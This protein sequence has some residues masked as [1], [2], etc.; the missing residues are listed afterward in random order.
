MLVALYGYAIASR[1]QYDELDGRLR[2]VM[3]HV[4]GEL[5]TSAT[6]EG[7]VR[8]LS[9]ARG[10]GFGIAL[11]DSVGARIGEDSI[12]DVSSSDHV[13]A[14]SPNEVLAG[15]VRAPYGPLTAFVPAL[16]AVTPGRGAFGLVAATNTRWRVYVLPLLTFP[17]AEQGRAFYLVGSARLLDLDTSLR[18][19]WLYMI[20]IA[21]MGNLVT[22]A[23]GWWL[24]GRALHPVLALTESA[25]AIARSGAFTERVA[26]DMPRDEL[27]R[28]AE[29]FN[30]MLERLER[31]H[32][33]QARFISDA[34][35]ELRAPLTV[36][37]GN[38]E[39]LEHQTAMT[40]LERSAA[41]REAHLEANRLGRLVADLLVLARA[42]VGVPMHDEIVELDRV[43]MNVLGE[44]RHLTTGQRIV[45]EMLTPIAISGEADRLHQ[46]VLNLL[47]N[48]IKYTP[49]GGLITVAL[50]QNGAMA[51]LEIRDTGIGIA[52]N[53]LPHVFDRFFRAD[54]ARARDSGGTGLGLSIALW[55][56]K[57]H[58]GGIDLVSELGQGTIATARLPLHPE[59]ELL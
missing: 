17:R 43:V 52:V 49:G 54:P 53:D 6:E 27:G 37:Q 16:R 30:E 2:S 36:I 59:R 13:P 39:L 8:V 47:E 20:I 25:S 5:A 42:D 32:S 18:R 38:L 34:S 1:T 50:R 57:Q 55:I 33:A 3:E 10:L 14:V 26:T 56:A 51:T 19:V 41:V 9:A 58:G 45:I 7:R 35:H 23:T 40:L 46:L 12:S 24:A 28:L 22:F 4:A 11:Y 48:A 29:T 44:A 15:P 21:I 31:L